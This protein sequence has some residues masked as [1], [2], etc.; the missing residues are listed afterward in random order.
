MEKAMKKIKSAR[1]RM[2][3]QKLTAWMTNRQRQWRGSNGRP[4]GKDGRAIA[5]KP[6]SRELGR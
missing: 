2:I 5:P 6:T 4:L 1:N 3:R